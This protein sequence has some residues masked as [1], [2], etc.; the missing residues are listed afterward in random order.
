MDAQ[1]SV[2]SKPA[3]ISPALIVGALLLISVIAALIMYKATG[4]MGAIAKAQ[5]TGALG[6]KA[7]WIPIDGHAAWS[8]PFIDA[9]NYF[10]W[11]VTALLFGMMIGALVRATLPARWLVRT[12]GQRGPLGIVLGAL[13]GTPLMLCSCCVSPV[14]D[15]TFART[16]KLGPSLALMLAAPGLNPADLLIIFLV[17]PRQLAV[18][19]LLLSILVVVGVSGLLGATIVPKT[20]SSESC[21]IDEPRP[22]WAGLGKA[23]SRALRST[24]RTTLPSVLVGAV[25]SALLLQFVPMSSLASTSGLVHLTIVGIAAVATL[26]ALPTFGEIPIALAL[27]LAHA[28]TA[29]VLA[30]LVAG[31]IINLPSLL[32]V[33]RSVSNRAAAAIGFAVFAFSVVGSELAGHLFRV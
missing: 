6:S 28:P 10:A 5:A 12:L 2:D 1:A 20:V 33:R 29:A 16:R 13:V 24:V 9:L 14:F 22:T 19:R 8:R 25:G 26:I 4:A 32:V 31:P 21:E 15:G 27:Y 30:V 18:A 7:R 23:I 17:F 11:I 3:G